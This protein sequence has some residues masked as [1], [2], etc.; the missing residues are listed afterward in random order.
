LIALGL[1]LQRIRGAL[2]RDLPTAEAGLERMG[3]DLE[4]VLEDVRELSRGLHPPL[5]SRGGLRPSLRA[6]ARRSPIPVE[7]DIDLP[8]R[9]PAPTEI[10]VYYIVSE[11]LT[12]AIKHSGASTVSITISADHAGGPFGVGRDG[13]G[14]LVNLH[15]TIADDGVGGATPSEGSGLMGLVDRVDA[16]GGRWALDSPPGEGTRFSIELPLDGSSPRGSPSG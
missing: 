13:S 14:R 16:H 4:S 1:D 15:A 8:E 7:L 9:P 2:G 11:A 6:L 5:L 10:A 12:N 3:Q